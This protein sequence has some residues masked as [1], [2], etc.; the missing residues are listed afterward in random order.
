ME[1]RLSFDYSIFNI[2]NY[3]FF[4]LYGTV[5]EKMLDSN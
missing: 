1:F 2:N 5:L 4:G 3:S